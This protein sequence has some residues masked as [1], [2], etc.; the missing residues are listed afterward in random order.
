MNSI[1]NSF[2]DA[3]T[4]IIEVLANKNI[5]H[6][7]NTY[8]ENTN[9][10]GDKVH[11]LDDTSNEIIKKI[12]MNNSN[13]YAIASEEEDK[14]KFNNI[15]SGNYLVAYDPLDGSSNVNSSLSVGTIFGIFK[16]NKDTDKIINV[17][18]NMVGA[19]YIL[20]G[21]T[22][23]M[24]FADQKC[25]REFF[26]LDNKWKFKNCII[27]PKTKKFYCVNLANSHKWKKETIDY[28]EKMNKTGLT[29]RWTGCMVSD[30]NRIIIEGGFFSYPADTNGKSKLRLLYECLPMAFII[31]KMGGK[32]WNSD[33]K[34]LIETEI[35][36]LKDIHK[37][38]EIFLEI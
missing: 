30:V 34:N 8:S 35:D 13:I 15:E 23:L 12:L 37:K 21:P 27:A 6:N 2:Q 4:K 9:L 10:T 20:Y 33:Y 22:P 26:L 16:V 36:F 5:I 17:N 31:N 18:K 29:Y 14:I 24:V 19:G 32:S 38:V 3:S 28:F 1:L 7:S 25:V 11:K